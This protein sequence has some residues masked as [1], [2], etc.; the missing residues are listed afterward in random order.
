MAAVVAFLG[1]IR[2]TVF[3]G[4]C[5]LL[6]IAVGVQTVRLGSAQRGEHEANQ[7]LE[8]YSTAV[9]EAT[10][11]AK[12]AAD[13][14]L[15]AYQDLSVKAESSYQAGR[16]SADLHQ[17]TLVADLRAGNVRLRQLWAGCVQSA[18]ASEA[19]QGVAGRSDGQ[20]DLRAESAGRIVRQGAD[21][22]N[23]VSWLQAELIATRALYETCGKVD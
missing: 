15:V 18:P 11:K 6:A 19:A 2:A 12:A 23:Q 8:A 22:D 14:A 7:R 16:D 1:G 13:R 5:L 21:A 3:A 17:A 10:K 9:I 20:A 4:L